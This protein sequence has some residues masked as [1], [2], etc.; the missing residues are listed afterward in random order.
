MSRA[1]SSSEKIAKAIRDR[2]RGFAFADRPFSTDLAETEAAFS[3]SPEV[4]STL[5]SPAPTV[6]STTPGTH[7]Y[8]R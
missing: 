1:C 3:A 5:R 4:S 6:Q 7:R 2:C 8:P